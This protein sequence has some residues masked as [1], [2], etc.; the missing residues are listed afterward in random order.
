MSRQ[1]RTVL[2]IGACLT[3]L[4]ACSSQDEE[5]TALPPPPAGSTAL[6][7]PATTPAASPTASAEDQVLT[8]Y[9]RFWDAVVAAHEA[10]DPQLP[11]LAKAAGEPELARIRTVVALNRQQKIS[12]R[13]PVT[14]SPTVTEVT[15]TAATVED[16]YDISKWDPVDVRTGAAIDVTEADGGSG[17]Y[18]ARYTLRRSAGSWIV[19]DEVSLG[20][21]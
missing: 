14:T 3:V 11:A 5:S 1:L 12:L 6:T 19:A 10:S 15:G 9:Q 4:A 17:R 13:G 21:C 20:G 8:G 2:S 7:A 18:K 16:C